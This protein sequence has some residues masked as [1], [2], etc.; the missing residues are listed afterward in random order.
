MGKL[1]TTLPKIVH[2]ALQDEDYVTRDLVNVLLN[3][4]YHGRNHARTSVAK[5][6]DDEIEK[7]TDAGKIDIRNF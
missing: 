4:I 6:L 5:T 2:E 1:E 7:L 3:Q